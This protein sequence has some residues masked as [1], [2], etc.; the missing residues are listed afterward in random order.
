MPDHI[1]APSRRRALL[2]IML[3]AGLQAVA[4]GCSVFQPNTT[5]LLKAVN[6]DTDAVSGSW[7]FEKKALTSESAPHARLAFA[8]SPHGDYEVNITFARVIGDGSV[9]VLLPVSG[10]QVL[11]TLADRPDDGMVTGLEFIEG[12]AAASN[13]SA[14]REFTM[15]NHTR[16]KLKVTVRTRAGE[17]RIQADIDGKPVVRWAGQLSALSLPLE[18]ALG[19]DA[20]LGVGAN[21]TVAQVYS[22]SLKMIPAETS[23][24]R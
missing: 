4:S 13:A 5:N 21:D 11:L 17:A 10:R 20:T 24:L 1:S 6:P 18:W 2:V 22:A 7:H 16:Y 19:S 3:L 9:H 14:D 8:T 15:V 23:S 12:K